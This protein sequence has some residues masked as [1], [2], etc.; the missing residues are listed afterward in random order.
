MA[1]HSQNL[2][3]PQRQ[4]PCSQTVID[5]GSS[6]AVRTKLM[7][8]LRVIVGQMSDNRQSDAK[9]NRLIPAEYL[10]LN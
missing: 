6:Q 8:V 5:R 2:K 4:Q 1:T 9:H 10:H 7:P 3:G